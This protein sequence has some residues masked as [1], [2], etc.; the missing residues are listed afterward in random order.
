M[1]DPTTKRGR[2]FAGMNKERQREIS[3]QGGK[4]AHAAGTAHEFDKEEARA[5]GKKGGAASG[6]KR[7]EREEK[8]P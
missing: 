6:R 7:R 4:A 2:G 1:T 3:S 5:A 8:Q